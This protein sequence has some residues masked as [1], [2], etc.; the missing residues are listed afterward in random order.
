MGLFD[1][2]RS[3]KKSQDREAVLIGYLRKKSSEHL[4]LDVNSQDFLRAQGSAT[5]IIEKSF[6][7]LLNK[8]TQQAVLDTLSSACTRRTNEAYGEYL[9]LL[10]TRFGIIQHA[11]K[12]GKVKPEEATLEIVNGALHDQVRRFVSQLTA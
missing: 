11:I 8:Q 7:L 9:F 2:L 3:N 6:V 1:G 5:E 12:S 4:G 10:F